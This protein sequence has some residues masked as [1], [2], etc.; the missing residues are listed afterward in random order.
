M[1]RGRNPVPLS[2][3]AK[4]SRAR[5]LYSDFTGHDANRYD[6]VK[7]NWPDVGLLVGHCDGVLYTT[8]RDGEEEHYIHTFKKSARP[9]LVASYDGKQLAL[10]GGNFQFKDSGIN[11]L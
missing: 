3:T 11:D 9:A 8:V 7:V 10:L 6:S 5:Q 1:T 2:Q 4:V